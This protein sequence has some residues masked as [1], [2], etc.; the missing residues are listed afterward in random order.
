MK[1]TPSF[2][3]KGCHIFTL[4]KIYNAIPMSP[5]TRIYKAI[6]MSQ[7]R[8]IYT[9]I[10]DLGHSCCISIIHCTHLDGANWNIIDEKNNENRNQHHEG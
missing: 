5:I 2:V 8:K 3:P 9:V 1:I 7:N 10:N 4:G 6:P